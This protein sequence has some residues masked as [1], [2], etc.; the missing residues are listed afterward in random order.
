M[1]FTAKTD[2]T[3][4]IVT[5]SRL[6]NVTGKKKTSI[7]VGAVT[8]IEKNLLSS[9]FDGSDFYRSKPAKGKVV[10]SS[11]FTFDQIAAEVNKHKSIPDRDEPDAKRRSS[12]QF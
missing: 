6:P 12:S 8:I 9:K 2:L 10:Q 11:L 7:G 4:V 3:H 5:P 1:S